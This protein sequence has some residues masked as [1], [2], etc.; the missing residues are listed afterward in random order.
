MAPSYSEPSWDD[1]GAQVGDGWGDEGE[2]QVG[3]DDREAGL[4]EPAA[5]GSLVRVIGPLL[6]APPLS[7]FC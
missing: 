7:V 4:E 3:S 1:D 5:Q 6:P 2:T